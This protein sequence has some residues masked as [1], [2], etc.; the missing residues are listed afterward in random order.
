MEQLIHQRDRLF[1]WAWLT[2]CHYDIQTQAILLN[3]LIFISTSKYDLG[4]AGAYRKKC[5][6]KD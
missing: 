3:T 1:Q 4:V 5:A 6:Y 2:L